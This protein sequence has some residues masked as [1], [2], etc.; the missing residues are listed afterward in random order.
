MNREVHVRF[1][2]SAGL[3][4]PAPLNYRQEYRDLAEARSC[5]ERFLEKVYN[6]KRLHSALGYRPP[7]EFERSLLASSAESVVA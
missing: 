7:I 1:W 5:I 4:C 2:E 6:G 3:R